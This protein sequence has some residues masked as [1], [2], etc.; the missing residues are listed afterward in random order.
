MREV[1]HMQDEFEP[2]SSD[3]VV[4]EVNLSQLQA[5]G[6]LAQVHQEGNYLVGIT[7]KGVRFRQGIQPGKML[8]K[9]GDQFKIVDLVTV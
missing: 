1:I 8:V 7:D 2:K 6:K 5:D 4:A 3:A 9:E